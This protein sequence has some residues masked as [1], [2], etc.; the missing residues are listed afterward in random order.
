MTDDLQEAHAALKDQNL[1]NVTA[2][3]RTGRGLQLTAMDQVPV[4]IAALGG[5][6]YTIHVMGVREGLGRFSVV[7]KPTFS[8]H[9]L[10]TFYKGDWLI[11][12]NNGYPQLI[13]A[14]EFAKYWE[15]GP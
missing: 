8:G 13:P 2:G 3:R 12:E 6:D 7:P 11:V 1:L 5:H 14:S 10:P 4:F 9:R 15:T